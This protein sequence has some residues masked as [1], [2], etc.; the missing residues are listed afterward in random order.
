MYG[1]GLGDKQRARLDARVREQSRSRE[2]AAS[3]IATPVRTDSD[4]GAPFRTPASSATMSLVKSAAGAA[5][6]AASAAVSGLLSAT[7]IGDDCGS[8]VLD[9]EWSPGADASDP[10]IARGTRMA[11]AGAGSPRR[12]PLGDV[13][14]TSAGVRILSKVACCSQ[15][16]NVREWQSGGGAPSGARW[17]N[18]SG[19]D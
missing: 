2:R 7:T 15:R 6:S 13:V 19:A 14:M 1:Y 5:R 12:E 16:G 3:A 8:M 10:A 4:A 11:L 17:R 18:S 9:V